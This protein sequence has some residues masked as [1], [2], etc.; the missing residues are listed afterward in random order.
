MEKIVYIDACIRGKNSRTRQIATPIINK[1]K[2]KYDLDTFVINDLDLEIIQEK[3]INRRMNGDIS[4]E[5][6]DWATRIKNASRIVISAP[7]WDMSIPSALKTF[8]ELCSINNIT[9]CINDK[10]CHGNCNSEKVLFI[11]TRGMDIATRD[12]LDQATS[13]L[14]ALSFLWGLGKVEVVAAQNLDFSSPAEIEMKIQNAISEG[15]QLALS[16]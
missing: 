12:P 5:V 1:L 7:F 9:F 3:A 11:T 14:E 16:F 15:L 13:Y 8:I 6:I 2:E 4:A 10:T